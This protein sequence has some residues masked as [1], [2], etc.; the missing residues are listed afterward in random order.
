M[1]RFS[2]EPVL[3]YKKQIE[4]NRIR[5][6]IQARNI[7]N[8]A[9]EKL[10]NIREL[11]N[12]SKKEFSQKNRKGMKCSERTLYINYI[13]NLSDQIEYQQQIVGK[14]KIDV[15]KKLIMVIEASKNRKMME[16][17]KKKEFTVYYK[18]LNSLET[19]MIDEIA[20]RNFLKNKEGE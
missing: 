17:L 20:I 1:V 9:Y 18:W 10:M 15:D 2:L 16:E 6:L 14:A 12:A 13:N 11:L 4:E 7:F 8:K 3:E 5:E 19:K